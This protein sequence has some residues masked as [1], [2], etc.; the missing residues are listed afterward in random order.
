[1]EMVF[2]NRDDDGDTFDVDV[3]DA[4]VQNVNV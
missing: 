4:D 3:Y 2:K 1:M